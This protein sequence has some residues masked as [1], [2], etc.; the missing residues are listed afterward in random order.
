VE[1]KQI[2][3]RVKQYTKNTRT[4]W[5]LSSFEN[6]IISFEK[7]TQLTNEEIAKGYGNIIK[8]LVRDIM[9]KDAVI[10]P[11]DDA[12]RT[13]VIVKEILNDNALFSMFNKLYTLILKSHKNKEGDKVK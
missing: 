1:I 10:M 9:T 11:D 5:D 4:E 8:N 13:D 2:L 12:E 6:F 7:N 3:R